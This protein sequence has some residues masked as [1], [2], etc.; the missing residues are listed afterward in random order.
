MPGGSWKSWWLFSGV[1]GRDGENG[2]TR[3]LFEGKS[4][5][6][7]DIGVVRADSYSCFCIWLKHLGEWMREASPKMEKTGRRTRR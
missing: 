4:G 1:G 2:W 3:D 5:H 7:L 6:D